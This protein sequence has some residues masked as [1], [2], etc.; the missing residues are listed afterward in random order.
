VGA[1]RV[2]AREYILYFLTFI[3]GV[4]VEYKILVADD[5]P[6]IVKVI[7]H[8]LM[9]EGFRV[10]CAADGEEAIRRFRLEQ[11]DLVITDIMMPKKD[12]LEVCKILTA[13]ADVPIIVLSA[14]GE[15]TDRI[16]GFRMGVDDYLIKPFSPSE[17]ALRVRAILRRTKGERSAS[18]EERIEI[19]NMVIDKAQFRCTINGRDVPLTLKEFETLWFLSTNLNRVFTRMQL[20]RQIWQSEYAADEN[21]VTVQ[22]CRLRDKLEQLT[23]APVTIQTVRGVGYKMEKLG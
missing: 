9:A 20:L 8:V 7:K 23:D 15:E 5:D 6:K 13:E 19:G 10:I 11:P 4:A 22:I 17:L 14:K 3:G 18:G 1:K 12:G 21:T 2:G 16:V